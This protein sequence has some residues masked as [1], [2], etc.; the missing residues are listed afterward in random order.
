ML[1]E[2]STSAVR[3]GTFQCIQDDTI[4]RS[5]GALWGFMME[6]VDPNCAVEVSVDGTVVHARSEALLRICDPPTDH[7]T[8]VM[9]IPAGATK[10]KVTLHVGSD[11]R[12]FDFA[13]PIK[14]APAI[15]ER[16]AV[17]V[18]TQLQGDTCRRVLRLLAARD[19]DQAETV[20]RRAMA[21]LT[22]MFTATILP[23]Q[24]EEINS[25]L[26]EQSRDISRARQNHSAALEAEM[27][28]MSRSATIIQ[29]GASIDPWSSTLSDL[30]SQLS[31]DY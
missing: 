9:R 10:A 5:M 21:S 2:L 31:A 14:D 18:A 16:C 28:T 26:L 4:A 12:A 17:Q 8:I 24:V 13:L 25:Q 1:Y 11:A 27:R 20:N 22:S 29:Q 7:S 30:Q 3:R 19:Y 15:D 23:Q 6:A